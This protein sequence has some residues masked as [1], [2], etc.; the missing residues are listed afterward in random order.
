[1]NTLIIVIVTVIGFKVITSTIKKMSQLYTHA[2]NVA[3]IDDSVERCEQDIERVQAKR[4]AQLRTETSRI[5]NIIYAYVDSAGY[6]GREENEIAYEI[7]RQL[8][9]DIGEVFIRNMLWDMH[10]EGIIEEVAG[11][12][13][14]S[15]RGVISCR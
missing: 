4:A 8:G 1:M 7:V 3:Q 15:D 12:Y 9:C 11:F 14:I 2:K 13:C 6:N 10:D 5:R